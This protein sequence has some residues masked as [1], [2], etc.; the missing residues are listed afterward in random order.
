MSIVGNA[1]DPH[2]V[3]VLRAAIA[4]FSHLAAEYPRDTG[5]LTGLG[6]SYLLA[7][8]YLRS[9][10][11]FTARQDFR[12]AITEYDRVDALGDERD[13]APGVARALIGLGEPARAAGLLSPLARS[14]G[15][16]GQ[17]LEL[18]ITADEAAHD[19]GC[20]RD[21]GATSRPTRD[22]RLPRWRRPDPGAASELGRFAGR[23]VAPVVFRGRPADAADGG[24][25]RARRRGR[26]GAGL[27]VHP[28]VP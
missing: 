18:L 27:V 22:R 26:I 13:A 2:M 15:F 24:A 25:V 23:C 14:A 19:F 4:I 28:R 6:D 8:T 1:S 11:P 12:L 7:G 9:S 21:C 3:A 16:P 5:V 20:G 17:L 10:E